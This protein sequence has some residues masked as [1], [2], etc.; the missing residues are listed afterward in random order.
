MN[1]RALMSIV[2]LAIIGTSAV[3]AQAPTLDK[4]HFQLNTGKDDDGGYQVH[5]AN[6]KTKR[7]GDIV[8]PDTY[9][10]KPVTR[11]YGI[12]VRN[13]DI[14]S[15]IIPNS[16]TLIG[17][18]AFLQATGLTSITIPASVTTIDRGAFRECK[19]LTSVTFQGSNITFD[20]GSR[21][22]PGDLDTKYKAGGAGTYTRPAGGTVWTK[23][24]GNSLNGT[25]TRADGTQITITDSGQTVTITGSY[26]NNGGR[27]NET[28][29]R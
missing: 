22:F 21:S 24:G 20:K 8:I 11:V 1:K 17:T 25:Y 9:N 7:N 23:Q 12:A 15:V 19:N 2:L 28:L 18:N 26:P 27:I 10:G 14:T 6:D 16:V 5:Q 3:L 4:L 29:R 13:P